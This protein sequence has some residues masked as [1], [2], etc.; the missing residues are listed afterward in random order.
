MSSKPAKYEIKYENL[1]DC[2][3]G[4]VLNTNIYLGRTN[5][6]AERNQNVVLE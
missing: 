1:F 3:T 2:E 6:N 4:F 5:D